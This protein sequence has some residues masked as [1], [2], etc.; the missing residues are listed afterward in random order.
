MKKVTILFL[1]IALALGT[2]SACKI[3]E[4]SASESPEASK[5]TETNAAAAKTGLAVITSLAKST[6][7]GTEEGLAEADSTV[8]AVLVSEDGKIL[9]CNIDSVQSK[10]IFTADGKLKTDKASTFKT[11][12]ELGEEYGMKK[13]SGIGK[14]WNEQA[15]AFAKYVV[16]KSADEVKGIAVDEEGYP[17]ESDLTSSVTIH[18]TDF[19]SAVEKAITSAKNLGAENTDKLGLGITTEMSKSKD[20]TAEE[21]GLAQ[22]YSFYSV[23]TTGADEKI[24]SCYVDSSISNVD[25]DS[26]GA[27]TTDLKTA[28]KTKQELGEEYGMKKASKIGKEWYEQADAFAAYVIGKT[29]DEVK[30]IA[31]SGEGY[32]TDADLISS[33][34]VHV[35]PLITVV[36]KAVANAK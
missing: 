21:A 27:I 32:A 15:D 4:P 22:A 18:I 5:P 35:G 3:E 9:A 14:E 12:Q 33:V 1:C 31:V 10:I 20:A 7:A 26:K 29:A 30:G 2:L 17:T 8:V 28:P 16:G 36:E 24:T 23:V 19:I 13:A 25:F 6:P 11:K 34:T